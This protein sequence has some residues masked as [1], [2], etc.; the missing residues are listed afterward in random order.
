[1]SDEVFYNVGGLGFSWSLTCRDKEQAV[2]KKKVETMEVQLG[3]APFYV[4]IVFWDARD[5][6]KACIVFAD[7]FC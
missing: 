6:E 4:N 5:K 7:L 2:K 1:M 3:S